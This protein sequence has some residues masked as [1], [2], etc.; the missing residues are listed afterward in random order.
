MLSQS[1]SLYNLLAKKNQFKKTINFD[2]KRIKLAL[3]KLGN[4]EKKLNNV[5]NII[6]RKLN[7]I[8]FIILL[9][10]FLIYFTYKLIL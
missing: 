4:P 10:V 1:I 8:T 9:I 2:L 6:D 5:I 7:L 3:F